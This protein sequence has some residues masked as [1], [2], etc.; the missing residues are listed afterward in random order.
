MKYKNINNNVGTYDVVSV[1]STNIIQT[2]KS[3]ST[4]LQNHK[5]LF[6]SQNFKIYL[7]KNPKFTIIT[8][9]YNYVLAILFYYL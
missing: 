3:L 1:I 6:I 2:N 8:I 5:N 9:V 4:G 7:K